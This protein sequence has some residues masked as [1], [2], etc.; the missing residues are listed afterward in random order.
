MPVLMLLMLL[1]LMAQDA[2]CWDE[3]VRARARVSLY[4]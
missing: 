1:L 4:T 3:R 2:T